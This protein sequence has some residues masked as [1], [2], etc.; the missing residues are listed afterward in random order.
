MNELQTLRNIVSQLTRNRD[1]LFFDNV[2]SGCHSC[3]NQKTQRVYKNQESYQIDC[4]ISEY[5]DKR[6]YGDFR[7]V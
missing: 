4:L 2:A 6:V 5:N 3:G 7:D 1:L